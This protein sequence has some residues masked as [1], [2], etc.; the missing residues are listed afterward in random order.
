MQCLHAFARGGQFFLA[1]FCLFA[2]ITRPQKNSPI[3]KLDHALCN[4]VWTQKEAMLIEITTNPTESTR[5]TTNVETGEWLKYTVYASESG[6]YNVTARYA[7][8][9]NSTA[10][11]IT[12]DDGT[13][14]A[15]D[16]RLED[17]VVLYSTSLPSSGGWDIWI[18]TDPVS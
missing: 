17:S 15:C 1:F 14:E 8:L 6:L 11:S 7:T 18:D 16:H 9:D 12:V 4:T 5:T 13:N 10:L 2:G 3:G